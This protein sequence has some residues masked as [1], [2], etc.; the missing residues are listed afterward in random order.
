[1]LESYLEE[2]DLTYEVEREYHDSV[3][4]GYIITQFPPSGRMVDKG[5]HINLV[6]SLGPGT[7][8]RETTEAT[9]E[10]EAPEH[11]GNTTTDSSEK[12]NKK[13]KPDENKTTD[14]KES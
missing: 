12:D 6:V 5:D 1:M 11:E 2:K 13:N 14:S 8:T 3:P 10:T 9:V 7:T 4:A